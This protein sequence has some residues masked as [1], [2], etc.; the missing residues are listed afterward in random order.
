MRP[1]WRRHTLT[2]V[3]VVALAATALSAPAS[4]ASP[5]STAKSPIVGSSAG[6]SEHAATVTLISGERVQVTYPAA[7]QPVARVLPSADGTVPAYETRQDGKDLYVFPASAASALAADRVD[8]E[9][10]N[11]TALVAAHLDDAHTKSVPVIA[12]YD[13]DTRTVTAAAPTPSGTTDSKALTSVNALAYGVTKTDARAA[14]DQLVSPRSRSGSGLAKLWL[15]RPMRMTLAD[16]TKQVGAQKAWR[17]GIDGK[18]S[19]VAVLDTGIDAGHPDLAGRIE[20]SKDF[21]DSPSGTDDKVGHGTHVASTIA[22]TGAA[23]HGKERG[24]APGASLLVGKVLDDSGSGSESEIIE[25]MQWAVSQHADVVSMS[26]GSQLP[27]ASCDD[28]IAQSVQQLST[29]SKSLFVIA[30]GNIGAAQHTISSPA[31]VQ[32][33]LTVGAVD[34]EDKV[35]QF[36]SRGPVADTHVLKPEIAAPGVDILAANAGGRGVYAYQR[37]SGTS[38]ATPHVAGAAA[39]AKEAN[40]GFSGAQLKQLLTSSANSSIPGDA[41]QVGAGRLDIGQLLQEKVTAPSSLYGGSFDFPQQKWAKAKSLTYTNHSKKAVRLHL[42]VT[43]LTGNDNKPIRASLVK[44]PANIVVPARGKVVIPVQVRAGAELSGSP[45]GDITAR[46]VAT[47]QGQHVSTAFNIYT[48]PPAVTV[49]VRVID[50]NG[51]KATGASSVDF[52][53]TDT[54]TGEH[55]VVGGEDQEFTVRPGR[56][57]LT[58]YVLTPTLGA[59]ASAA[60]QSVSY[61]ARPDVTITKDTTIVLDARKAHALEVKT[62]RSSEMRSTTLTFDRQWPDNWLH[63]GSMTTSAATPGVY[64]DVTGK[65]GK[66]DGSFEFGHW[67]RRI[68]PIVSSMK[69]SGGWSLH[70]MAGSVGGTNLD[71]KGSTQA[72]SAGAGTE[73][74]FAAVDAKDKI[75]LVKLGATDDDRVVQTRAQQAGAKAVL[76]YRETPGTWLPKTGL[77]GNPGTLPAYSLTRTEGASLASELGKGSVTLDWKA[78]AKSP[79][80]YTLGF[81]HDGQLKSAQHHRVSDSSL[82]SLTSKYNSMGVATDFG[83]MTS[84]QRPDGVAFAVGGIDPVAVPSTRTEFLTAGTTKWSKSTISSMPF[85]EV[86]NDKLR[87]FRAGQQ[88]SNNWYGGAV[89][90]GIRRDI[91]GKAQLIAER[92]ANQ[93]GVAPTIWADNAGHWSDGGS[94]G[95]LGKLLLKRNGVEVGQTGWPAGVFDVPAGDAEYELTLDTSKIGAPAQVWQRSTATSTSWTFRS[96]EEPDVYSQPLALLLP[97]LSLPTDG[98]KTVQAGKVSIPARVE[99]N[100]G[101]QAGSLTAAKVWTSTDDGKTWTP[102]KA[103]LTSG[104]AT[105]TVNHSDDSGAHVSLRVELTDAHGAKVSQTITRAYDVR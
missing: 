2:S 19:T 71:G 22:G 8:R 41:Q 9:L 73:A 104:G 50:R 5:A 74:D 29:S 81:F 33:A 36:S 101:Y 89:T 42:A 49:K 102:G 82:G 37:M 30:A 68:A 24:V 31:C 48:A 61:L 10:F 53:D 21:T 72:V 62:Q 13:K 27:S 4:A 86:M 6:T 51:D 95:D 70:P 98:M 90:P 69:T 56:F 78:Q 64:A 17:A 94:F 38:M 76:F 91:D 55:T 57:F 35:A 20:T 1:S 79:Y 93:L 7:G 85:G 99:A 14:W 11:V 47:G 52:V 103:K 40:P 43:K 46:I 34:S 18:G 87:T 100:P 58:S 84:A 44:L 26:L 16:S 45:L 75:A 39:I 92:Q 65:V 32:Q 23:S 80:A 25:G 63:A 97:R 15:D 54:A 3:G 77:P 66:G 96:H 12:Q 67:T 88:V 105:L 60:P 28:P 83:D 59:P